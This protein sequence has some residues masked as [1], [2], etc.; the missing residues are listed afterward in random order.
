[1]H[2]NLGA[3]LYLDVSEIWQRPDMVFSYPSSD[4]GEDCKPDVY[5]YL[6]VREPSMASLLGS[7]KSCFSFTQ[8][9]EKFKR[10]SCVRSQVYR[11]N[12]EDK[13]AKN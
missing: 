8:G 4:M 7:V 5:S 1:M 6:H 3:I 10:V 12:P 9:K 13:F 2:L 11:I